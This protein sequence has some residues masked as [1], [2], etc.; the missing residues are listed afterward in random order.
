MLVTMSQKELNRIP[1]LE[2]DFQNTLYFEKCFIF[3]YSLFMYRN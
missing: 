1:I 3:S 2:Q